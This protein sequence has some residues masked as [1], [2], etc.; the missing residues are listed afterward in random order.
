MTVKFRRDSLAAAAPPRNRYEFRPGQSGPHARRR[1]LYIYLAV[2]AL[3]SA[4]LVF[5]FLGA[6]RLNR[7]LPERP[8]EAVVVEKLSD[9]RDGA[10]VY[11]LRVR[12]AV[13]PASPAEADLVPED[14]AGRG[15]A[16]GPH[17]LE[18]VVTTPQ[19]DWAAVEAGTRLRAS[20]QL[21]IPRSK[22]MVRALYLDHL[23]AS[24]K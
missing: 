5:H 21:N 3:A 16:I 7:W 17:E 23:D 4:S 19:V 12:V 14:Y 1:L 2:I 11:R 24:E 9:D 18:D 15:E 6:N 22:I 20:Y 8:G 10:T 13:P